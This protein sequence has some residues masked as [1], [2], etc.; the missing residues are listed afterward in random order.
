[1]MLGGLVGLPGWWP[2]SAGAYSWTTYS[3]GWGGPM[4]E[5]DALARLVEAVERYGRGRRQILIDMQV[6]PE[7]LTAWDDVEAAAQAAREAA[8]PTPM[9]QALVD[10]R[11][12]I[13]GLYP[14]VTMDHSHI[15]PS[16]VKVLAKIDAALDGAEPL[17]PSVE[18]CFHVTS[19]MYVAEFAAEGARD[20]Y[21][22]TDC[23]QRLTHNQVDAANRQY[24]DLKEGR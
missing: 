6:P 17:A 11:I 20:P 21:L 3:D 22:C 16:A 15:P 2:P 9:R 14:G 1:M 19:L 10:A 13:R 5:H 4:T 24:L 8:A 23:G 12:Y 18:T 7:M